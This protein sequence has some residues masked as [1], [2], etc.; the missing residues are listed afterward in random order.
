MKENHGIEQDEPVSKRVK[1]SRP[2][3]EHVDEGGDVEDEQ[4][5]EQMSIQWTFEN[6]NRFSD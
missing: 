5:D 4:E 2:A 6:L 3:H 1:L